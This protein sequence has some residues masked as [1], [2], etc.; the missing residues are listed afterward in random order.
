MQ[1]PR[2]L[3]RMVT[4]RFAA[5]VLIVS[6]TA[7][8]YDV[9]GHHYTLTAILHGSYGGSSVEPYRLI[10]SFCAELPDLAFD[11][12]ATSQ[13]ERVLYKSNDWGWGAF[14]ACSTPAAVHMVASQFYLHALTGAPPESVRNA[15]K[16]IIAELDSQIA[17]R[18][19]P[20]TTPEKRRAVRTRDYAGERQDLVNLWCERGF[21]IHLLGD[22]YAHATLD[23][24]RVLYEPGLGHFRDGHEPDLVLRRGIQHWAVW[25]GEA[26]GVL[27]YQ[28]DQSVVAIRPA[29]PPNAGDDTNP[30]G[31]C[32]MQNQLSQRAG[33][34]N[35][36]QPPIQDWT[37]SVCPTNRVGVIRQLAGSLKST[38]KPCDEVVAN[39]P[40]ANDAVTLGKL[41]GSLPKPQCGTAWKH[42]LS[43]AIDKF[44]SQENGVKHFW[45]SVSKINPA[46]LHYWGCDPN[47]DDLKNGSDRQ[48]K[49]AAP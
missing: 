35:K 33:D 32:E 30:Y 4:G 14:G 20:M 47:G 23:D 46:D 42:Y 1:V 25:V 28:T 8:G 9:A 48:N 49:G 15:A 41:D 7:L 34:W 10:E 16:Q 45:G 17:K 3:K 13:R 29:S 43:L 12:D 37:T 24:S 38:L 44:N 36:W 6:A 26:S 39:G 27:G 18:N 5:L 19:A 2:A 40:G 31:E 22:T 11:L 21:A